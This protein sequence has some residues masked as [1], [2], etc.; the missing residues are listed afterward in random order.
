MDDD[1]MNPGVEEEPLGYSPDEPENPDNVLARDEQQDAEQEG[2]TFVRELVDRLREVAERKLL[3]KATGRREPQRELPGRAARNDLKERAEGH[4]LRND[5]LSDQATGSRDGES[6]T[7]S[8]QDRH[9]AVHL[10]DYRDLV[11]FAQERGFRVTSTTGDTHKPRSLHYRGLAIDVG[12]RGESPE[13]IQ[14][15][16]TEAKQGG[17]QVI[18][19][20]KQPPKESEWRG[21]HLHLQ[22]AAPSG[23]TIRTLP[24]MLDI[25]LPGST[26]ILT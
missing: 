18:D 5:R 2:R 19:E 20:R 12:T 17:I 10:R 13:R 11:R 15:F 25:I 22:I 3:D 8:D 16:I 26:S 7:A 9:E 1:S 14:Q 6:A 24:P 21:P 4:R 23:G